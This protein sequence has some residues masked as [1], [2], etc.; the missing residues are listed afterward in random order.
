MTKLYLFVRRYLSVL[1][2]FGTLVS[3][4]QQTVSG[5]VT[6]ADDGSGV[7]GV[8]ILEKGTTNGTVSDS[9]GNYRISV[10]ANATLVYSFVGYATT[11]VSVGSQSVVNVTLQS[12]VTALSEV[13]VTGYGSQEKKEITSAVVQLT[14]KDFNQGNVNDPSQLLQGKVAGLSVYNRGGDPNSKC[15]N[16]SARYLHRRSQCGTLSG[17]GWCYWSF[18]G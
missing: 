7:P 8:N 3:F 2:V 6:G 4:A 18:T 15:Y 14:S 13:V 9:D 16:S 5:K 11:E 17:C 10:G 12:D 1:L